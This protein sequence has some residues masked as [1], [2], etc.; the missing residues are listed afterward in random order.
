[1]LI[2]LWY[3]WAKYYLDH[4]PAYTEQDATG[5]V[6]KDGAIITFSGP[7]TGLIP[8]MQVTG[9]GLSWTRPI[10][11]RRTSRVTILKILSPTRIMLS[12]VARS[13]STS[14]MY[15]FKLQPLPAMPLTPADADLYQLDFSK[16]T[17]DPC[18]VLL[19]LPRQFMR[20]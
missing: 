14:G 12:Q 11:S 19:S 16:E 9:P 20:S 13:A 17:A 4:L 8:G 7:V 18:A 6:D 5:S 15:S 2:K 10:R 3:S 1:M